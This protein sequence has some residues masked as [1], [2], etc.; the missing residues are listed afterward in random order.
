MADHEACTCPRTECPR[1]GSC[2]ACRAHHA[3]HKKHPPFCDR[4]KLKAQ[5][6]SEKSSGRSPK[7]K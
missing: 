2:E 1:H 5:Q 6:R 7:D 4:Q 3:A